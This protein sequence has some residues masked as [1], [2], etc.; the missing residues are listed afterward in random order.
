MKNR[1]RHFSL[2][3]VHIISNTNQGNIATWTQRTLLY[4]RFK[5]TS[6]PKTYFTNCKLTPYSP[7]RV[8]FNSSHNEGLLSI[9][10]ET[11]ETWSCT[12][13]HVF[14]QKLF[15][16][17]S[18]II[19][20]RY[21]Q[22]HQQCYHTVWGNLR[23]EWVRQRITFGQET[24]QFGYNLT[25]Y[26]KLMLLIFQL[27]YHIPLILQCFVWIARIQKILVISVFCWNESLKRNYY[28]TFRS[29]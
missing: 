15:V 16:M 6:G 27:K 3:L 26:Y 29:F 10:A 2:F 21:R 28:Y 25:I 24:L 13:S 19:M 11:I 22:K 17:N 4:S 5:N 23:P 8:I 12:A 18:S 9:T 1:S 7:I 14:V 20:F